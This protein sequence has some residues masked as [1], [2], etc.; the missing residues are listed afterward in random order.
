MRAQ[1]LDDLAGCYSV[2]G[3]SKPLG[4]ITGFFATSRAEAHR[5]ARFGG[6]LTLEYLGKIRLLG[7]LVAAYHLLHGRGDTAALSVLAAL[8]ALGSA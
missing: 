1:E 2:I 6:P 5:K 3:L 8:L 4:P 7:Q